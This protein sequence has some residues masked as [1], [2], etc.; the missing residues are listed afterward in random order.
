MP[1]DLENVEKCSSLYANGGPF[2]G[3]KHG[4]ENVGILSE[5]I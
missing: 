1:H 2:P 3:G 4:L 5:T